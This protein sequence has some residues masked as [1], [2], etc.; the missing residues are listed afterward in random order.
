MRLQRIIPNRNVPIGFGKYRGLTL[1]QISVENP[2]YFVWLRKDKVI[3]LEDKKEQ[4]WFIRKSIKIS[5][6]LKL[7]SWICR[8]MLN[9]DYTKE[10]AYNEHWGE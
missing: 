7:S 2:S 8:C 6:D 4:S 9:D 10:T 5:K 3:R 1:Q